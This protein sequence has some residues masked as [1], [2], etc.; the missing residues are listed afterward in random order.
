MILQYIY[1]KL[2]QFNWHK[3]I[4]HIFLSKNTISSELSG[5]PD[6]TLTLK[7]SLSPLAQFLMSIRAVSVAL[8]SSHATVKD[9]HKYKLALVNQYGAHRAY[10][11]IE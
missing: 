9:S 6:L 4:L 5:L 10:N 1:T 8:M 3:I 7:K 2:L 11:V